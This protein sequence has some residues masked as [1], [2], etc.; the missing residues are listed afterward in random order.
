MLEKSLNHAQV[1]NFAE[2]TTDKISIGTRVDLKDSKGKVS[3]YTIL[4]AWDSDPKK[5]ILSYQTPLAR[6]ML[7]KKVNDVV[8]LP[9]GQILTVSS[10]NRW[11]Q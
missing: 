6:E 10:I 3:T 8:N 9:N 4:G 1:I 7:G 11:D 5:N 2:V